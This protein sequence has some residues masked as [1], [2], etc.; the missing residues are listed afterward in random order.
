MVFSK[1]SCHLWSTKYLAG[2]SNMC[3]RYCSLLQT[4]GAETNDN[5]FYNTLFRFSEYSWCRNADRRYSRCSMSVISS[6]HQRAPC[7]SVHVAETMSIPRRAATCHAT[8]LVY[9]DYI[10]SHD[11]GYDV[12]L[13]GQDTLVNALVFAYTVQEGHQAASLDITSM[14]ALNGTVRLNAT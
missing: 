2:I 1:Y 4:R 10:S 14:S 11:T 3:G 8:V 9:F 5:I 7:Y 13:S 6:R 12:E